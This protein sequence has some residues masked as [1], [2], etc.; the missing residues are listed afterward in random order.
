MRDRDSLILENLYAGIL[1]KESSDEEYLRLAE[2][3]EENKEELQRMVD[4]VANKIGYNINSH[5][6]TNGDL[7][8]I[9]SSE[10]GGYK[11]FAD[12]A[13]VGFFFTNN[14]EV[15][16][17]YSENI[18]FGGGLDL[19]L[20]GGKLSQ[21]RDKAMD[22]PKFKILK[23]AKDDA[24]K[25]YNSIRDSAYKELYTQY[26]NKIESSMKND[27]HIRRLFK[28]DEKIEN[29]I[30]TTVKYLI[31]DKFREKVLNVNPDIVSA[32]KQIDAADQAINDYLYPFLLKALPNVRILNIK[33]QIRKPKIYD[34]EG[35]TPAD[36]SLTDKLQ[37]AKRSGHD[38]VIFENIIDPEL[39]AT[40]YVVFNSNQ[41][42]L[43]DPV[44]FD[45]GGNIIPISQ[46]FDSSSDDIRY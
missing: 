37:E 18:G 30:H 36:F 23:Q 13:S 42:K 22:T 14:P 40:H 17:S 21:E 33:L 20:G 12:S 27:E 6:G 4:G 11:T 19:A 9:F 2:N 38:G 32:Q 39:S 44:T 28:T 7:F 5:H 26:R 10:R 34:A 15:A 24:E 43:A 46:R 31:D 16:K 8:T 45:D 25:E 29:Y 35:K 41:I 1:L 3:P